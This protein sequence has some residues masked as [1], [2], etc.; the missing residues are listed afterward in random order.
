MKAYIQHGK[1]VRWS[2][3]TFDHSTQGIMLYFTMLTSFLSR[4]GYLCTEWQSLSTVINSV[5]NNFAI[6][7]SN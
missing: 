1:G 3:D 6:V 5:K 2:W 7:S 4:Y